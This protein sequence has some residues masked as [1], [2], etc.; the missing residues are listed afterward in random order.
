M[1]E[2]FRHAGGAIIPMAERFRHADKPPRHD[3]PL[4]PQVVLP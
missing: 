3:S 1:A 4:T 2:R